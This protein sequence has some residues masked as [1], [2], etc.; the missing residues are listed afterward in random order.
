M[1][2]HLRNCTVKKAASHYFLIIFCHTSYI[3]WIKWSCNNEHMVALYYHVLFIEKILSIQA[4][5]GHFF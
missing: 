3:I 4:M 2:L 1:T 5:M